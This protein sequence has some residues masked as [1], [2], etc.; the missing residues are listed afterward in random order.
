MLGEDLNKYILN[1]L[2][3]FVDILNFASLN[4]PET[5]E[6]INLAVI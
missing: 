2:A 6:P 4:N 3:I 1:T 5:M